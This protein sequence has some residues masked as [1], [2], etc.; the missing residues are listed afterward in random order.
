L[1]NLAHG[2]AEHDIDA[3][4]FQRTLVVENRVISVN[5]YNHVITLSVFGEVLLRVIDDM[6]RAYGPCDVQVPRTTH[7][8]HLSAEG[9]GNLHGEC[10][11]TATGAI[12]KDLLSRLSLSLIA[13][14]LK[15][16]Q[17]S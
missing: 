12:D 6:I 10:A 14:T 15:C 8:C 17:S 7:G 13:N 3:I 4:R 11:H 16:G 1:E 2:T 5:G 9:F